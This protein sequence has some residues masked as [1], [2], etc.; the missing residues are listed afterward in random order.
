MRRRNRLGELSKAGAERKNGRRKLPETKA[1]TR[2]RRR[3]KRRRKK[4]TRNGGI[5]T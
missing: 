1:N 2:I 5:R 4:T 3:R